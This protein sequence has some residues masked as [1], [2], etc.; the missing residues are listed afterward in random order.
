MTL[1]NGQ[2]NGCYS[3]R[4]RNTAHN[5]SY[6]STWLLN[7]GIIAAGFQTQGAGLAGG[8]E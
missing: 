5:W 8:L 1:T 2:T 3:S 6:R 4:T 7:R